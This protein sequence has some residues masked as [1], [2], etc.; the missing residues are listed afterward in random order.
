MKNK[1]EFKQQLNRKQ[2]STKIL[3]LKDYWLQSINCGKIKKK[4][5]IE[6]DNDRDLHD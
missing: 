5:S 3:N 1:H 2:W 4:K 6:G